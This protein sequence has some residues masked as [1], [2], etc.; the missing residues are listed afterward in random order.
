GMIALNFDWDVATA[1]RRL[2][3]ALALAPEDP[4]NHL[5]AATFHSALGRHDA[6]IEA[7]R[8]S[9]DLDPES[10]AIRSDAGFFLLRAGRFGEAATECEMVL[11]LDPANRYARDCLLTAYSAIGDVAA[12]RRHAVSLLRLAGAPAAV[13]ETAAN[14]E[15]PRRTYLAWKL[16]RLL[17]RRDRPA[18]RIATSYLALGDEVSALHWL[19]EAAHRRAPLL[20]FVPHQ[21]EF[22]KISRKARYREILRLAGLQA[23]TAEISLAAA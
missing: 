15:N 9:V 6:A 8:R 13:V 1:D 5:A 16:E 4:V 10:M 18:V 22:A 12:A 3:R 7:I 20:V 21:A 19:E 17:A 14:V 2:A 11:R 23:L